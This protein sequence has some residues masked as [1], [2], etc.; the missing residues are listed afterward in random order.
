MLAECSFD[1]HEGK[2]Q[3]T[4]RPRTQSLVSADPSMPSD[5]EG[6]GFCS[7]Q[8]LAQMAEWRTQLQTQL[9]LSSRLDGSRCSG[10]S[11]G[12]EALAGGAAP[13]RFDWDGWYS[14]ELVGRSVEIGRRDAAG[15]LA[16]SVTADG[17][18]HAAYLEVLRLLRE[19]VSQGR[20]PSTSAARAE[21]IE[22]GLPQRAVPT[23]A[24]GGAVAAA[25][26]CNGLSAETGLH[27]CVAEGVAEGWRPE[28]PES[29]TGGSF[30]LGV[31]ANGMEAHAN[32]LFPDLLRAAF[33]VAVSI[34]CS[35]D[36]HVAR[37][38][39]TKRTLDPLLL[40]L[41]PSS[42]TP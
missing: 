6:N 7:A 2:L 9:M 12:A 33:E 34:P 14:H 11:G 23:A 38:S 36:P 30:A 21:V 15:P 24:V 28:C 10:I 26:D 29:R 1:V 25:A 39:P 8:M 37:R 13:L 22:R 17:G 32:A 18:P 42:A 19:I 27:S 16:V 35:L 20:W 5:T 40:V 41:C 4:L 31:V 3:K